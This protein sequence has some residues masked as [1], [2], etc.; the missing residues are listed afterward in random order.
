MSPTFGSVGP[1]DFSV[2]PV[3]IGISMTLSCLYIL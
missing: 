1:I 3:G 2:D